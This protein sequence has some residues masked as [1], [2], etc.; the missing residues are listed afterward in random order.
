LRTT[1]LLPCVGT[2]SQDGV[3]EAEALHAVDSLAMNVAGIDVIQ[4]RAFLNDLHRN[5]VTKFLPPSLVSSRSTCIETRHG[6]LV[7]DVVGFSLIGGVDD[8]TLLLA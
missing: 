8:V 1:T 3:V 7:D 5:A 2:I 6:H 4:L